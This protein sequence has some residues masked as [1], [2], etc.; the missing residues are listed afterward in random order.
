MWNIQP[1]SEVG[2]EGEAGIF[3]WMPIEVRSGEDDQWEL[4]PVFHSDVESMSNESAKKV[5]F[6]DASSQKSGRSFKES[7]ASEDL[8]AEGLDDILY[9]GELM[10]FHPGFS[11]NFISRYV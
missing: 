7:V 1:H 3:E 9:E 2:R 10:K 8:F 11:A 5:K 6:D 4:R